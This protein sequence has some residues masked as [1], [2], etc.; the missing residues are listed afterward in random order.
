MLTA[1]TKNG[2]T[3]NL[4][5]GYSREAL[6]QLRE[7]EEFY[8]PC[9]REKVIL[10]LGT[11]KIFHFAHLREGCAE[12][13]Y[14]RESQYHL[15]GKQALFHWL[16]SLGIPA[17]L[18]QYDSSIQQRPDIVFLYENRHYALEFQCSPI[19][20]ELFV[21]RTSNYEKRGYIPL[22]I[23]GG[24]QSPTHSAQ[25][26][27]LSGFHYL[28]YRCSPGSPG[29]IP[30]F[31]P[32]KASF[33]ILHSIIPASPLKAFAK[34]AQFGIKQVGLL[35]ILVPPQP[36]EVLV[37]LWKRKVR[38]SKLA[39]GANPHSPYKPFLQQ[40]YSARKNIFLLPPEIGIPGLF[41]VPITS[42]PVIWQTYV[43]LD[44][45]SE[46]TAGTTVA[47][48]EIVQCLAERAS[49]GDIQLRELPL[50]KDIT[51]RT[52]A[53]EYLFRLA[54][55]GFLERNQNGLFLFRKE[56]SFPKTAAE[57][58]EMEENF[59]SVLTDTNPHHKNEN[60]LM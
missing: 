23:L 26:F 34:K 37:S 5:I 4:A 9:C 36:K 12:S 40:L 6:K 28:F 18:E 27:K 56:V 29:Y 33:T 7:D 8:C 59:Y 14:D 1:K 51:L 16:R 57:Q 42:F 21:K 2:Q 20:Q 39:I 45:L 48:E 47:V 25:V 49:K 50:A 11:K 38:Q 24:N 52:L 32:E 46:R 17:A 35:D 3:I 19:P 43:F 53:Y 13:M 54:K 30:F 22:W 31:C 60:L 10:K 44:V 58:W 41:S 55:Q 15:S